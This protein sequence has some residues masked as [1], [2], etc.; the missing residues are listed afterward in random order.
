M[1]SNHIAAPIELTID[2]KTYILSPL[3]M[4]DLREL[5]RHFQSHII[6]ET[7]A[8][9]AGIDAKIALDL[10][11]DAI[12]ESKKCQIGSPEFAGKISSIEGL[13][14]ILSL[15]LRAKHIDM[16]VNKCL[17]LLTPGNIEKISESIAEM[18]GL[19][20]ESGDADNSDFQSI[21]APKM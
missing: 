4:R 3:T 2:G 20:G 16:D 14:K 17:E 1:N 15:S 12:S 13:A 7:K 10:L 6:N 8:L 21:P 18:T 9:I 19:A 11:R 5:E